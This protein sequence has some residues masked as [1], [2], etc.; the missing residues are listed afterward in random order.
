MIAVLFG[1]QYRNSPIFIADEKTRGKT[2]DFYRGIFGQRKPQR[3][4][5]D[6]RDKRHA[7]E[8]RKLS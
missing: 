3:F 5:C 6:C 7:G 4:I 8:R 1:E 2:A